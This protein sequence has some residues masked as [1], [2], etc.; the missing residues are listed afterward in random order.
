MDTPF[1]ELVTIVVDD[2]DAAIYF[3]VR[4]SRLAT[5]S[6]RALLDALRTWLSQ[7]WQFRKLLIVTNEQFTQQVDMI[8]NTDL[9]LRFEIAFPDKPGRYLAYE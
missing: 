4:L 1:L 6:D 9:Q 2:Y 8:G 7:D 3:W 5:E